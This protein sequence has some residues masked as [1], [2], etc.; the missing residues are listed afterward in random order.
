VVGPKGRYLVTT[1]RDKSAFAVWR[2]PDL[3]RVA[4]VPYESNYKDN[5]TIEF[6]ADGKRM[7]LSDSYSSGGGGIGLALWATDTWKRIMLN[8]DDNG[9][10]DVPALSTIAAFF[11]PDSK[12]LFVTDVYNQV[13]FFDS[14]SGKLR[15]RDTFKN[16]GAP[17]RMAAMAMSPDGKL[18]VV[19]DPSGDTELWDLRALKRRV[20][21]GLNAVQPNIAWLPKGNR[22][23]VA[24]DR[25]LVTLRNRAGKVLKI[26]SRASGPRA[27]FSDFGVGWLN[28][29]A[30]GAALV[31]GADCRTRRMNLTGASPPREVFPPAA[32]CPP[33]RYPC[34]C[35]MWSS[36]TGDDLAVLLSDDEQAVLHHVN[37]RSGAKRKIATFPVDQAPTVSWLS[38]S[39]HVVVRSTLGDPASD[40]LKVS[41]FEMRT[42]KRTKAPLLAARAP[43]E[44]VSLRMRDGHLYAQRLA[45]G[46][47]V[48]LVFH[49][50]AGKPHSRVLSKTDITLEKILK[51]P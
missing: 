19:S 5:V 37:A 14:T 41:F 11:T 48:E 18:A 44:H 30:D 38:D 34:P 6:S 46:E 15:L 21:P 1:W 39:R 22:F 10:Q 45:D 9:E 23:V 33:G 32:S 24:T 29:T 47:R 13:A 49:Y 35:Q 3:E 16:R 25:G 43:F 36:R 42:G 17:N 28:I 51:Q 8:P 27:E 12:G 40:K 20:L 7:I 50:A 4:F 31:S 2:L 26:L